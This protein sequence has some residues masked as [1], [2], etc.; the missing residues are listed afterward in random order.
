VRAVGNQAYRLRSNRTGPAS[1]GTV[2]CG[3]SVIVS[4]EG[5][6]LAEAGEEEGVFTALLSPGRVHA[7]RE[8]FPVLPF[9]AEG[10]DF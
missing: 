2:F 9:R 7:L 1:D 4:P 10:V 5:E 3:G 8:R 6:F